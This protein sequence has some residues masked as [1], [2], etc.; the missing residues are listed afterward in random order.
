MDTDKPEE[1]LVLVKTA[2]KNLI[3]S[4]FN[5]KYELQYGDKYGFQYGD[6]YDNLR[7][8]FSQDGHDP[9]LGQHDSNPDDG[10][11]NA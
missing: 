9:L 10:D 5:W 7:T 8:V 3:V 2:K 11:C 4:L 6:K 1:L